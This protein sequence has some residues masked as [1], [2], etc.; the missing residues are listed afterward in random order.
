MFDL[1]KAWAALEVLDIIRE[2]AE[3]MAKHYE[4]K[5][6]ATAHALHDIAKSQEVMCHILMNLIQGKFNDKI[7][8]NKTRQ[9]ILRDRS[10]RRKC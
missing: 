10:K 1:D 9:A 7:Y 4:S 3:E 5:K 8:G 6:T 2:E